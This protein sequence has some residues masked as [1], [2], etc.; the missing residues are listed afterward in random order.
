MDEAPQL[1]AM[2]YR[3]FSFGGLPFGGAGRFGCNAGRFGNPP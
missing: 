3:F 1:L 2:P